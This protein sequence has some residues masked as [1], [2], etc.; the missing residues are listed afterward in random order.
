[1]I[2]EEHIVQ[3]VR[4]IHKSDHRD[5]T[6]DKSQWTINKADE[7]SCF[8]SAFTDVNQ[9]N[10]PNR[11][12]L[13]FDDDKVAYLGIVA[14]L[15]KDKRDETPLL[16]IAFFENDQ[17]NNYWHG[18]P[19]DVKRSIRNIPP[20]TIRKMWMQKKLLSVRTINHIARRL[21]CKL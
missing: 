19:A 17:P 4:Y 6:N 10:F 20:P 15:H 3:N 13:H 5:G 12:G 18:Y 9:Q 14:E 2:Q 7:R 1:M 8:G 11:W 21:R 16:F